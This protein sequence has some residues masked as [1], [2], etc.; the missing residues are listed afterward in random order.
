MAIGRLTEGYKNYELL[1]RMISVLASRRVISQ[2]TI[3]GEGPRRSVLEATTRS[4]GIQDLVTFAGRVEDHDLARLLANSHLGLFP[5][6][7]SLAEKGFEGFGLVVQEMAA[8]GLPVLVG[9]AAGAVDAAGAAW[10]VLLNP[11]DLREWVEAVEWL[12]HDEPGRRQM[13][14]SAL[15]WARCVDHHAIARECLKALSE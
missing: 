12:A 4:L 3:I 2:L 9:R 7:D 13:A 1:L 6:R 11:D 14:C 5:S 8:A 10:S 15:A